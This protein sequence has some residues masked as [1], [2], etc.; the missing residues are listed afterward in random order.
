[1]ASVLSLKNLRR[2][3]GALRTSPVPTPEIEAELANAESQSR[4]LDDAVRDLG[5]AASRSRAM[6]FAAKAGDNITE[7]MER[8]ARLYAA[9]P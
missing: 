8:A 7:S 4:F 2:L 3:I 1:M 6:E 5:T 9:A